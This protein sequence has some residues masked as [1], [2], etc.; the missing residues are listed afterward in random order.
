[1]FKNI[2]TGNNIPHDIYAI[3]EISQ[4]SY[5]IKYEIN[6]KNGCLY[7]DRFLTTSMI[8]PCNYGY[9][10]N[11]LSEDGDP[12]DIL[13]LTEYPLIPYS[14]ILSRPIGLLK[15][16]DESGKDLK[17]IAVPNLKTNNLYKHIY[18]IKHINK[19]ILDKIKHFFKEYKSNEKNKWTKIYNWGNYLEA[20]KEILKSINRYSYKKTI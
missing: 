20:K 16:E 6:K 5:P 4:N 14:I 7:V 9:I 18:S 15:M 3:I 10:N 17:I 2:P 11:T 1:M 19:Y 12:L 8:Y 13:V